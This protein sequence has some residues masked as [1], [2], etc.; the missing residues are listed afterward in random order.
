MT[1]SAMQAAVEI[2]R[3]HRG[4]ASAEIVKGKV[5]VVQPLRLLIEDLERKFRKKKTASLKPEID[6]LRVALAEA[7]HE[8]AMRGA[9]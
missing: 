1:N 6:A 8:I 9:R 5:S 2:V 4:D 7:E 3:K